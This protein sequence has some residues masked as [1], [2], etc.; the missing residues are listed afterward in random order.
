MIL[1]LMQRMMNSAVMNSTLM[2]PLMNSA[3]MN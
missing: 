3:L 2:P 1:P